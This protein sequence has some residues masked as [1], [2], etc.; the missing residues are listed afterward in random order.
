MP[1]FTPNKPIETRTPT[2]EVEGLPLGQHRF[3]L[4]VEDESG[5]KS[6]AS[7]GVVTIIKRPLIITR[8]TPVPPI[9]VERPIG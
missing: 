7:I 5:N 9:I 2:I 3:Q 1:T 8:P 4:V 6:A